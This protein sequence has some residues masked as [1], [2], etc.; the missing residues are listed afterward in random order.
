MVWHGFRQASSSVIDAH[1]K[2]SAETFVLR[3][4]KMRKIRVFSST[5]WSH[6]LPCTKNH[7][8]GATDLHKHKKF[9]HYHSKISSLSW[10]HVPLVSTAR[11]TSREIRQLPVDAESHTIEIY[12]KKKIKKKKK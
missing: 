10:K 9:K 12:K 7:L 6:S 1:V 2:A 5:T 4:I 3:A 11:T 8:K